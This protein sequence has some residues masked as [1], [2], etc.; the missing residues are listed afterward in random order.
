[1]SAEELEVFPP[2]DQAGVDAWLESKGR[3]L[4]TTEAESDA[5][6]EEAAPVDESPETERRTETVP[7]SKSRSRLRGYDDSR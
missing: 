7:G 3:T 2:E 5:E 4:E 6:I 1:M